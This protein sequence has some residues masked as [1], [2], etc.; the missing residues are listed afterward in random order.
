MTAPVPREKQLATTIPFARNAYGQDLY[1]PNGGLPLMIYEEFYIDVAGTLTIAG[2]TTDGTVGVE[3]P[4]TLLKS[5]EVKL[6]GS[7]LS[8]S[9]IEIPLSDLVQLNFIDNRNSQGPAESP[10]GSGAAGVYTFRGVYKLPFLANDMANPYKYMF[11]AGRYTGVNVR[12]KWGTEEDLVQGGDRTKTISACTATIWPREYSFDP[13][14][15]LANKILFNQRI[16]VK[17]VAITAANTNFEMELQRTAAYL[18]GI[19]ISTFFLDANGVET[20]TDTI[21]RA[22][23]PIFLRLNDTDNKFEYTREFLEF[24]MLN[25][26]DVR[27]GLG[28]YF[29]DI[30]PRGD[31]ELVSKMM[32][33]NFNTIKVR[34]NNAAPT[35]PTVALT[36][37]TFSAAAVPN[38]RLSVVKYASAA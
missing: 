12:I 36:A 30:S 8:D 22:T 33:L 20:P 27:L 19:L 35:G 18:R 38:I 13:R 25:D 6:T 15:E 3:N 9:Y 11:T 5:I 26:Y 23:D 4:R 29:L 1:G 7:K 37:T 32:M 10:I 28:R 24:R 21:I 16:N 2:G 14:F 34:I 31:E 17:T